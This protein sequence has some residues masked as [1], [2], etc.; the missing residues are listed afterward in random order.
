MSNLEQA[1]AEAAEHRAT[2]LRLHRESCIALGKYC[3]SMQE[4]QRLTRATFHP[5]L[6]GDPEAEN[7][8]RKLLITEPPLRALTRNGLQAW[9]GWQWDARLDIV[10]LVE[11]Y[12]RHKS[13]EEKYEQQRARR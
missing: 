8:L 9:M 11:R 7:P 13:E 6:G 1:R 4:V 12:P 3:Q 2:L 10:P 5:G